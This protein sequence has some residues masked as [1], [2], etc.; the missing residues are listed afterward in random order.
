MVK[1]FRLGFRSS[2]FEVYGVGL[3]VFLSRMAWLALKLRIAKLGLRLW[4][5][6]KE[7]PDS[8]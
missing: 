5:L 2:D 8:C 1:K 7:K 4:G 3:F 6:R